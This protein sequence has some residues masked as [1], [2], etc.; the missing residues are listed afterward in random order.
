MNQ[1]YLVHWSCFT[2]KVLYCYHVDHIF[3]CAVD[4]PLL[5]YFC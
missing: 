2:S 3:A 4:A 1:K 5:K